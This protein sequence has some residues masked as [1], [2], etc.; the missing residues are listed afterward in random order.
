MHVFYPRLNEYADN[1]VKFFQ[2]IFS[3]EQA[4]SLAKSLKFVQRSRNMLPGLFNRCVINSLAVDKEW[5]L[6]SIYS[7][8]RRV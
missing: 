5:S 7:N 8:Y 1:L 3:T 4:L 6:Y 2:Q